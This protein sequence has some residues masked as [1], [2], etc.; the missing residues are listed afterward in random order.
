LVADPNRHPG[1]VGRSYPTARQLEQIR[2]GAERDLREVGRAIEAYEAAQ[3]PPDVDSSTGKPCIPGGL[4]IGA[5]LAL[6]LWGA[7]WLLAE[8]VLSW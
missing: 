5:V 6:V 8:G 7:L 1:G 3:I 4:Y 2:D